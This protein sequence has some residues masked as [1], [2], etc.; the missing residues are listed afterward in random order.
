M[1]LWPPTRASLL[2]RLAEPDCAA[3]W[4]EFQEI[5]EPAIYRYARSRSLQPDDA[6]E[7]VQEVMLAVHAVIGDWQ[8]SH[9]PGSFRAW[10]AEAAR[11]ITLQTLRERSRLGQGQGGNA[12]AV[13]LENIAQSPSDW[14]TGEDFRRWAFFAAAGEVE[15]SVGETAWQAFWL[16]AVEGEPAEEV[17]RKLG[18]GIGAVYTAK[19]RVLARIR[20]RAA[21]LV[22]D[23]T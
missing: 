3:A 21:R 12:S 9:R 18:M 6:R 4:G 5:Y 17:A 22:G 15:R 14:Q 20:Q 19:C 16:T 8:P 1:P 11:R 13:A 23:D 7:V 2:A 10:L